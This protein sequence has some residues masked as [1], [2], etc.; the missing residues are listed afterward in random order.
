MTTGANQRDQ[1]WKP[2]PRPRGKPP[3]DT[4][5]GLVM[6]SSGATQRPDWMDGSIAAGV[7]KRRRRCR[8]RR[9]TSH[10]GTVLEHCRTP[11][12]IWVYFIR[13]MRH[14]VPVECAA[15]LCGDTTRSPSSGT[16][17]CSPRYT[18]TRTGSCCATPSGW[19]RPTSATPTSPRATLA[20]AQARA[21]PAEAVHLRG[22]RRAQ[23]PRRGRLRPRE[24]LLGARKE[25]HRRHDSAGVAAHLRSGECA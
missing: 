16:T 13:H 6:I 14:N 15:E 12:L 2:R 23:E 10:R 24:A 21:T 4:R 19:T 7:P 8:G 5:I 17:A 1:D 25:S 3:T 9:L 20:G 22:Y 11:L 18:A